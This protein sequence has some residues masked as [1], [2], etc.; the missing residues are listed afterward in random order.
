MD[1]KSNFCLQNLKDGRY[2][3]PFPVLLLLCMTGKSKLNMQR[4]IYMSFP[5]LPANAKMCAHCQPRRLPNTHALQQLLRQ[6][7]HSWLLCQMDRMGRA[8]Y[9]VVGTRTRNHTRE[10]LTCY[11]PFSRTPKIQPVVGLPPT[12]ISRYDTKYGEALQKRNAF[13]RRAPCAVVTRKQ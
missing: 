1:P 11:L 12:E 5:F 8:D 13:L 10:T 9:N 4:T 6:G 7:A 3:P 2:R